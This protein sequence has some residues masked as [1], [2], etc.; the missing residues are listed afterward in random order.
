MNLTHESIKICQCFYSLNLKSQI[1]SLRLDKG[2]FESLKAKKN[3]NLSTDIPK[4]DYESIL[5]QSIKKLGQ[6]Y[7]HYA[8]RHKK[9]SLFDLIN[10]F[11]CLAVSSGKL[12][13]TKSHMAQIPQYF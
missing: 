8:R 6:K 4:E 7:Q 5:N 10:F 9:Y 13:R 12:L 2:H 11:S 3:L 1:S